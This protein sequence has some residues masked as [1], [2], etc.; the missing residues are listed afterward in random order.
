MIVCIGTTPC[1]QRS[2]TF[3]QLTVDAVNRTALVHDYASGKSINAARVLHELGETHVAIGFAGGTRGNE[4]LGDLKRVGI[5][6]DF[7]T[8]EPHTRQCITVI[9]DAN[10][11]AT[12]LVEESQRIGEISWS[13]LHEKLQQHAEQASGGDIWLFSGSMPPDSPADACTSLVPMLQSRGVT[14]IADLSGAHLRQM[15]AIGNVIAKVNQHEL[16]S[17]L[18]SQPESGAKSDEVEREIA[19]GNRFVITLGKHGAIAADSGGTWSIKT[20]QLRAVSA[21]GSGDAFAGGLCSALVRGKSLPDACKLGAA[22]GAANA[23]TPYA[24]HLSKSD[25]ERF[26]REIVVTKVDA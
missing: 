7:V 6:H 4:L 22:C 13:K 16:E 17:T 25:V 1:Y 14:V 3:Q 5:R 19:R 8:V 24:G 26:L 11:T 23:M 20:I 15:L 10:A 2:M 9:D 12:E 18:S 21:V